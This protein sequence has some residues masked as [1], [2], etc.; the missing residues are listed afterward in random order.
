MDDDRT[1]DETAFDPELYERERQ[2]LLDWEE[3]LSEETPPS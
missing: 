3:E 2:R 1:D